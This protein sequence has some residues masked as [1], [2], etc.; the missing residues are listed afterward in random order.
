MQFI[1]PNIYLPW[2]DQLF[3]FLVLKGSLGC[4]FFFLLVIVVKPR[5]F[6]AD[7]SEMI[8]TLAYRQV[9][10][11]FITSVCWGKGV[12]TSSPFMQRSSERNAG[13]SLYLSLYN[14]SGLVLGSSQQLSMI[15]PLL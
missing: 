14:M 6:Q 3:F 15:Y 5:L 10:L 8:V 4:K 2:R 11:T 1:L 13:D 12:Y 7:D 9:C